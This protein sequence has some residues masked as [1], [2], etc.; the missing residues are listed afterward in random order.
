MKTVQFQIEGARPLLMHN[1]DL[2]SPLN[3][4][5]QQLKG[6]T[7]K[8]KKTD[9][10]LMEIAH[11]EWLGG[12]YPQ[13]GK[14]YLVIPGKTIRRV[15][16]EGARK[17]KEGKRVESG[18]IPPDDIALVFPGPQTPEEL[19]KIDEHRSIEVVGVNRNK[20]IRCRPFFRE[21]RAVIAIDYLE[22]LV[23]E[24]VLRH[25]LERAGREVGVGDWRPLYG[26]FSVK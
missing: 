8:R 10:D 22:D 16:I 26:L 4:Y 13:G 25:A 7:S 14:P 3:S 20:T 15:L 9:A 21:W 11:I 19:W 18:I 1:G 5:A 6:L 24:R 17:D 2:A 12:M 23:D